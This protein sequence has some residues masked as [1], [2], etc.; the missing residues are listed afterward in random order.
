[1]RNLAL[2]MTLILTALAAKATSCSDSLTPP[3]DK[4]SSNDYSAFKKLGLTEKDLLAM[5][6][7]QNPSPQALYNVASYL[8]IT[9][10][11]AHGLIQKIKTDLR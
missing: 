10:G 4:F 3:Q 6:L 11:E 9:L 5:S 1:M 2:C 7:G 8:N